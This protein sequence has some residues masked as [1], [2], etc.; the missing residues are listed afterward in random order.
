MI[1]ILQ[2][3]LFTLY[4]EWVE[5]F[6]STRPLIRRENHTRSIFSIDSEVFRAIS[7]ILNTV[8]SFE[9]IPKFSYQCRGFSSSTE[10]FRWFSKRVTALF[11]CFSYLF[12]IWNIIFEKKITLTVLKS[13][14]NQLIFHKTK[15]LWGDMTISWWYWELAVRSNK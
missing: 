1:I 7:K 6:F 9:A 8:K 4:L 3:N 14:S 10:I 15:W 13:L 11:F 2:R 12:W 5:I